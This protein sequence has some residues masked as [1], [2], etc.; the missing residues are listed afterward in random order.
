MA[1]V[2]DIGIDFGTS[3]IAVYM[4][5]KG[6]ILREPALVAYDTDSDKVCAIGEEA[7]HLVGHTAGNNVAI[8]PLAQGK[9]SDFMITERMLKYFV[10]KAMGRRGI[11][12][13]RIAI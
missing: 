4:R 5:G 9:I 13:P 7:K 6:I 11:L 3:T 2:T 1:P 10:E 8:K 12:K